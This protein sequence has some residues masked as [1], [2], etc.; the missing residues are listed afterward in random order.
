VKIHRTP[1]RH[2]PRLCDEILDGLFSLDLRMMLLRA[3][4]E[5][6]H[7]FNGFWSLR[8]AIC[9]TSID[10]NGQLITRVVLCD[11]EPTAALVRV[12]AVC[13]VAKSPV[14]YATAVCGTKAPEG[15]DEP[16]DRRS[17]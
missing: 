10:P 5:G 12:C 8:C 9:G 4:A 1:R 15:G 7:V 14:D 2:D 6:R 11:K 3:I 17:K 13:S 16:S